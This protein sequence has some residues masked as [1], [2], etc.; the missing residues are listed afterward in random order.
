MEA[1]EQGA[2]NLHAGC[3]Y[4]WTNPAVVAGDRSGRQDVASTEAEENRSR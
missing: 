3:G 2:G 4:G 1:I